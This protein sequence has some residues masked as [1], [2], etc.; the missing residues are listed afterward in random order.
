MFRCLIDN[1]NESNNENE[2]DNE[3]KSDDENESDDEDFTDNEADLNNSSEKEFIKMKLVGFDKMIQI[4]DIQKEH[5]GKIMKCLKDIYMKKY[6]FSKV[7]REF[8]VTSQKACFS[9]LHTLNLLCKTIES[10]YSIDNNENIIES[11]LVKLRNDKFETENLTYFIN[12][13]KNTRKRLNTYSTIISETEYNFLDTYSQENYE[14]LNK[15]LI[16]DSMITVNHK[17]ERYTNGL[18]SL[19]KSICSLFRDISKKDSRKKIWNCINSFQLALP[20][21]TT[22]YVIRTLGNLV[23][24]NNKEKQ[25]QLMKEFHEWKPGQTISTIET[26]IFQRYLNSNPV[27]YWIQMSKSGVWDELSEIAL[28]IISIPPTEAACERVF[29]TRRNIMTKN[30]SNIHDSVVEA[31]AH[32]K[33]NLYHELEINK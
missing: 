18:L 13:L 15:Y 2:S 1:E 6:D 31:R 8:E 23:Y 9:F 12:I 16:D 14:E 22:H 3:N 17:I 26:E 24:A 33:A 10:A 21:M 5:L 25:D 19:K 29:S 28:R 32:L 30:I 4:K 20:E 7:I 11:F 27:D